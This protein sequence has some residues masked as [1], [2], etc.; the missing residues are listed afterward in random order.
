MSD[1]VLRRRLSSHTER[2]EVLFNKQHAL[3][4]TNSH[5]LE[6]TWEGLDKVHDSVREYGWMS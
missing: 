3:S 5:T 4:T 6:K 2:V 1:V